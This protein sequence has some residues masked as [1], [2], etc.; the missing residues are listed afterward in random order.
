MVG[1]QRCPFEDDGSQPKRGQKPHP[2]IYEALQASDSIRI[3]ELK[4]NGDPKADLEGAIFQCRRR[5]LVL[6]LSMGRRYDAMSYAWGEPNFNRQLFCNNQRSI[7]SITSTVD[8]M[9]RHMRTERGC[10]YLWIDA[11]C[12]DQKNADEMRQQIP[13][14]GEV[15]DEAQ[16]VRIWLGEANPDIPKVF[17]SLND[18]SGLAKRLKK[19]VLAVK[20]LVRK[21]FGDCAYSPGSDN[22]VVAFFERPWFSRRW[23]LPEAASS[24]VTTVHCGLERMPWYVNS[25]TFRESHL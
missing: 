12:L 10:R 9:L 17:S 2:Y 16:E 8:V 22:P 20:I 24:R 4:S 14:M 25:D 7:L 19:P 11:V 5:S 15:Y 1:G 23:V 21:L 18:V 6:G 3:L 13:L